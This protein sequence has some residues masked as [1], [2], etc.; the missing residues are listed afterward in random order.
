MAHRSGQDRIEKT[1]KVPRFFVEN[2]Q[3][4]WV[5]L[6]GVLVWGW[7]G[8]HSM[9]HRKDPDIPVRVAEAS[10]SSPGA[11]AQQV[12]Q[13]VTRPIQHAIPAHKPIHPAPAP[14]HP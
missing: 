2:P 3:V 7:F 9:P 11:T 10:C 8:S 12:E 4:S 13:F 6:V 5:L 1:Q 14:T